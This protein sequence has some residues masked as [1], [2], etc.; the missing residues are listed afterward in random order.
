MNKKIYLLALV[1]L[2][3][4]ALTSCQKTAVVTNEQSLEGTWIVTGITSDRAYDFN[5]DGRTETDLYGSYTPCQRDI[6]VV[7][8]ADGYG[9]MRQGCNASWQNITW[10]LSNNN[11]ELD[12]ILPDDQLNLAVSQF[13]NSTIRGTDQVMLNGNT[14]NITYTFQRR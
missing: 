8:N 12:I 11:R 3:V 10:Q 1:V 9:Q 14:F 13:S 5:N 6:V 7:F 2:S 4:V